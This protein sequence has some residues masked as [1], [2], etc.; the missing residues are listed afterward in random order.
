M[1]A[2]ILLLS[3]ENPT[4]IAL[5][6]QRLVLQSPPQPRP[7]GLRKVG[8]GHVS[9]QFGARSER[10]AAQRAIVVESDAAT[11]VQKM[12]VQQRLA[13]E[14]CLAIEASDSVEPDVVRLSA[15]RTRF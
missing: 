14:V 6:A 2:Q 3:E 8:H 10:L 9:H 4:G 7:D 1:L 12:L 5:D 13:V 11:S 15:G